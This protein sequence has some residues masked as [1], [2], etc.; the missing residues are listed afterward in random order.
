MTVDKNGPISRAKNDTPI[1]AEIW[2]YTP[3]E[4]QSDLVARVMDGV[5][6]EKQQGARIKGDTSRIAVLIA[7]VVVLFLVCVTIFLTVAKPAPIVGELVASARQELKLGDRAVAIVRPETRISFEIVKPYLFFAGNAIMTQDLGQVRYKVE[8][9]GS[10]E[11]VTPACRVRVTGTEFTTEVSE[12]NKKS[13]TLMLG[14][15]AV[16]TA[17]TVYA[18]SVIMENE[19]GSLA[20]SPGQSGQATADEAP[21]RGALSR[22]PRETANQNKVHQTTRKRLKDR[23][24]REKLI[25][26]IKL[27][28]QRR[29]RQRTAPSGEE[30]APTHTNPDQAEKDQGQLSEES[31][32]DAVREIIPEIKTCYEEQL[33]N[34]S[35]LAGRLSVYF[36]I[37]GEPDV[38]GIIDD[39]EIVRD[40]SDQS[41]AGNEDFTDCILDSMDLIE[42][43]APEDGGEVIVTYPFE[44]TVPEP[45]E[46]EE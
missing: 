39:A 43:P 12:M 19:H 9:G 17:V 20:L 10:F 27:A 35:E 14:G 6:K 21:Q 3:P 42:L 29:L 24:D 8:K 4:P 16:V 13:T 33:A 45:G 40:G 2:E 25:A 38:G 7:A 28:K 11:V 5:A 34:D 1:G 26:A 32:R 22:T 46:D 44:F 30:S 37:I 15:A 36:K 18:G 23:A 31:I 41:L